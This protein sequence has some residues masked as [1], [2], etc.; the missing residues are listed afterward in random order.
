MAG[1]IKVVTK[2]LLTIET[3]VETGDIKLLNREVINDDI[4]KKKSTSSKIEENPEPIVRLV[5]NKLTLT[6]GAMELLKVSPDDKV[7]VKYNKENKPIIGSDES[8]GTKTGNRVTK[9]NTVSFKGDKYD[10]LAAFGTEFKLK[11]ADNEGIFLMVNDKEE[12][13]P[14]DTIDINSELDVK[15]LDDLDFSFD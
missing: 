4:V 8:F 14:E 9:S 5:D 1:N 15:S 12:E 2:L 3:D 7:A 13:L 6:T 11:P 10:R